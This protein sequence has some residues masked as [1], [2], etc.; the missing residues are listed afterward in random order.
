MSGGSGFSPKVALLL[1]CFTLTAFVSFLFVFSVVKV[2]FFLGQILSCF[3]FFQTTIS[4][5]LEFD[6]NIMLGGVWR[7]ESPC[8]HLVLAKSINLHGH[9][10]W[11][12]AWACRLDKNFLW[13]L[14]DRSLKYEAHFHPSVI[15]KGAFKISLPAKYLSTMQMRCHQIVS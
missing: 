2:H 11:A 7:K 15:T 8:G 10:Q 13:R 12:W 9:G 4:L 6:W 1:L 5:Y 3:H 14:C